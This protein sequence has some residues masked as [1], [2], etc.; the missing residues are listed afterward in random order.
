MT[1]VGRGAWQQWL[2]E[3]EVMNIDAGTNRSLPK[4][5]LTWI[6]IENLEP[7]ALYSF[8]VCG[9]SAGGSGPWSE[10]FMSHALTSGK[11]YSERLQ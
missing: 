3:V 10:Y 11:T 1:L 2:Y 8:R 4:T 9:T 7:G 6:R 5:N